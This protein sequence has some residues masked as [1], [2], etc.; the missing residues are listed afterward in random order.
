MTIN[1]NELKR[2]A[3]E[4]NLRGEVWYNEQDLPKMLEPEDH[5]L[6]AAANPSTI[7]AL[8]E[9]IQEAETRNALQQRAL[10]SI[11][12]EALEEAA[13]ICETAPDGLQDSSFNGAARAIRALK[14][15]AKCAGGKNG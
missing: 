15:T 9:R 8:I 1:L 12:N 3:E 11:R 13:E 14:S 2:L 10:D 5:A 4:A 7:L 6:I